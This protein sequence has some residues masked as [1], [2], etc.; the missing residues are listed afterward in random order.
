MKVEESGLEARNKRAHAL[1][2]LRLFKIKTVEFPRQ[3]GLSKQEL[4]RRAGVGREI[5]RQ[6]LYEKRG[7]KVALSAK[8]LL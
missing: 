7:V 1:F 3:P 6:A 5:L 2:N 8:F 4:Y